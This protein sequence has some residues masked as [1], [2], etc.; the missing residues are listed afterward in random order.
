MRYAA[1]VSA[2]VLTAPVG[3]RAQVTTVDEGSF[4]IYRGAASIGRETFSIR[5]NVN[6]GGDVFVA[7]AAVQLEDEHIAPALRTD[8]SGAPLAYQVEVRTGS[9][10][11]ERLSGQVGRGRFSARV[12][13]PR[14][15]SA[16]EYI[17]SDGALVLDDDVF[18]QYYFLAL[19]DRTGT[20]PV[21]IPRRNVQL[22]MQVEPLGTAPVS[23]GGDPI[24]ARRFKL[25]EPSGAVRQ[26]WVDDKG[27]V[28]KVQLT[29]QGIT[30]VRDEPPG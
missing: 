19:G 14:G 12:K 27:R 23:I 5:R 10:V 30:A 11:Q 24:T 17:V 6:P 22:A 29:A 7:S 2:I 25:T 15:E 21:I 20:V 16:K 28:L 8:A 13:T 26:L 3:I 18:H 4:T 1:I 9:Q